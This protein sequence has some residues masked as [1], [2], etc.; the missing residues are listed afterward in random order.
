MSLRIGWNSWSP[1]SQ[2]SILAKK[3]SF[4]DEQ[5]ERGA[6]FSEFV[7]AHL[8]IDT[9][10]P[11]DTSSRWELIDIPGLVPIK[12]IRFWVRPFE[13]STGINRSTGEDIFAPNYGINIEL[14]LLGA[15]VHSYDEGL[16]FHCG[17]SESDGTEA[18]KLVEQL[19]QYEANGQL[20]PA[21][22]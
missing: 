15:Y 12:G 17:E 19:A 4:T 7:L 20:I 9:E 13:F 10:Q 2:A 22:D 8:D 6:Q 21:A 11:D 5:R 14:G 1:E 18:A 16:D 3:E